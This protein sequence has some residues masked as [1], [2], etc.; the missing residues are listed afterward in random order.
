VNYESQTVARFEILSEPR[1]IEIRIQLK[2]S[3]KNFNIEAILEKDPLMSISMWTNFNLN[4]LILRTGKREIKI[5]AEDQ[6][7][8]RVQ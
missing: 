1:V 3:I 8:H 5:T 6:L 7:I 2:T 4:L